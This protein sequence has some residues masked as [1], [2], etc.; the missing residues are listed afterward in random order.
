M[1]FTV[2]SDQFNLKQINKKS[3]WPQTSVIIVFSIIVFI[4][5]LNEPLL[6]YFFSYILFIFVYVPE[7]LNI[8][9]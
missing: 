5:I 1:F 3:H 2:T 7:I 6:L 9:I 4:N 8:T